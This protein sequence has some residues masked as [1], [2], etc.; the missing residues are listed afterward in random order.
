MNLVDFSGDKLCRDNNEAKSDW[1]EIKFEINYRGSID[2]L[3]FQCG[4]VM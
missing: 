2:L 4:F 1:D 3:I